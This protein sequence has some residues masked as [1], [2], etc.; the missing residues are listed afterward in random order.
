MSKLQSLRGFN[1]VLPQQSALFRRVFA[2]A[3][4]VAGRYGYGELRL[5]LLEAT[6]LFKRAVGEVTD[7][8]EKE[9]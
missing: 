4:D 8:I 7:V 9:M 3:A 1:D 2:T 5:P 6:T